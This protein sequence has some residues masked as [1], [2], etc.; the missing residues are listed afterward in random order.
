M[1]EEKLEM[2]AAEVIRQESKSTERYDTLMEV[3][4][5]A[6]Q[7]DDMECFREIIMQMMMKAWKQKKAVEA[8]DF[9]GR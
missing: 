7:T 6:Q 9:N 8:E 1:E 4:E 2:N 3:L 5:T